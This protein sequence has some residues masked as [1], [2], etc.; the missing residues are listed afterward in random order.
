MFDLEVLYE[1]DNF[2]AVNKPAGILVHPIN[3]KSEEETI[4]DWLRLNRPQVLEVG[5]NLE[6]RPGIVHRLDRDTSGVLVIAKT[7]QYFKYLKS[8]FQ[9]R[10]LDK[11]YLALVH[12]RV[13]KGGVI[14]KPIGLRNGTIKRTVTSQKA[15]MI[16]QAVTKFKV[17]SYIKVA[18]SKGLED[19]TLL[20]V[21][22][23]TGRTHQIRVHLA[24]IGHP[25]VG[26]PIYGG[27]H[28]D[29]GGRLCLHAYSLEL[30]IAT[31]KRIKIVADPPKELE[32]A[33]KQG[34]LS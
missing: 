31:G 32:K 4:V 25:I 28:K 5:D 24:S 12:G 1:D 15:K 27:K 21:M 34:I 20:E 29:K 14:D 18:T 17:K 8:L 2:I 26:D 30:P 11:T 13:L 6:L 7:Q 9:E 33:F 10:E 3:S 19:C 16:K 23:H 22:P